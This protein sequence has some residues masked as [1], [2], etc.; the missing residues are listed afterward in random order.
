MKKKGFTLIEL[1]VVIAIITILASLLLPALSTAREKARTVY[2]MNNLKQIYNA[3]TFYAED[4]DDAYPYAAGSICWGQRDAHDG[5]FCWMQQLYPYHK[6]KKLYKCP[7]NLVNEFCYFLGCRAAYIATGHRAS[8]IRAGIKY[9]SAFVLSGDTLWPV[10]GPCENC[11][12][13]D[14][15]Q[16]CVGGPANGSPYVEWRVHNGGQNILF[17]DGHVKWYEG[18]VPG[19]MTFRYDEMHGWQ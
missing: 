14:Y 16:N 7:S 13:D 18:Y 9:P 12:K 17:A 5:T 1:L 3:M 8:V 4:Y 10:T 19:E 15:S 6:N 11:D 2:C